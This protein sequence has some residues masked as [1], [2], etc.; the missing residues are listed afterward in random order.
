MA[1]ITVSTRENV[2][3]LHS[4]QLAK[5]SLVT[6]NRMHLLECGRFDTGLNRLRLQL[7]SLSASKRAVYECRQS[8]S[9]GGGGVGAG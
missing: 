3:W 6:T 2:Q 7:H 4:P 5:Q 8:Q 1:M 9:G